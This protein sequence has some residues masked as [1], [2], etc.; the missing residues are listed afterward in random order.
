[1][2]KR[3]F[4]AVVGLLVIAGVLA[5]IKALQIRAMIEQGKKAVPPPETVTVAA[6]RSESWETSIGA[7][8]SLSAVQGVTVPAELAGKVTA[9]SFESGST[10]KKGDL[11][12][13]QDTTAEE[14]QL[15]GLIAQEKLARLELDRASKML[16]EQIVSQSEYDKAVAAYEQARSQVNSI[17]ATISK[18]AIRAP[19]SGRLGIRQV[20][21]G[22]ML[23]EGDPVVTLQS[24]N[25]IY[26]NFSL[27]QQQLGHL[28]PGLSVLIT[29]DALPG[30]SV[31]GRITAL[32]P[33]VDAETRNVQV[34]A[35][36]PNR[37]ESLRPGMFVNVAVG[38]PVRRQVLSIPAT[39]VLYAPYGDSVFVVIDSKDHKGGKMLRQQF[40]RLGEKKGDFVAV[41]SGLKEGESV[42]TTGVFK[43]RN[44][45]GVK[46]D[47]RLAPPFKQAP[48]PENN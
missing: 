43:L 26:V 41:A 7:I 12:I 4:L 11:L 32:N 27:P 34:Q 13:R 17:S 31:E 36:L 21:L 48:T 40:V 14:A 38:L 16:K 18:K 37:G 30:L 1:M 28:H 39:S 20:N 46:V 25:P 2:K 19:F 15:P 47:N 35:T 42:V 6:V 23:R 24:L 44:G 29:C 3:L 9:I 8:G 10:A 45:Q 22:Q 5:G 33:L